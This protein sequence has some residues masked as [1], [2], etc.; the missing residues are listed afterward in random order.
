MKRK[1]IA[2]AALAAASLAGHPALAQTVNTVKA[3]VIY[4]QTHEETSGVSGIG[5]PPGADATVGNATTVLFTYERTVA[6]NIGVELVLGWPP[7]IKS[8]G[9]G[10]V[11]FLGEVMS[12]KNVAPTLM[13]NYHFGDASAKLRPPS[14]SPSGSSGPSFW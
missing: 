4:Y 9:A 8:Q 14:G 12:A 7:T 11:A 2:L 1:I 3:G 10:S 13:V 6:P 5:V